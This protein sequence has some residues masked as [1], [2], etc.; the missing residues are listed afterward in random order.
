MGIATILWMGFFSITKSKRTNDKIYFAGSH[1][2]N[3]QSKTLLYC[4]VKLLAC[5]TLPGWKKIVKQS[6]FTKETTQIN[7]H[8]GRATNLQTESTTSSTLYHCAFAGLINLA[9]A[10]RLMEFIHVHWLH[11]AKIPNPLG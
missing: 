7:G 2:I 5:H 10:Y 11:F 6:A 8:W 9:I 1:S 3:N 4:S